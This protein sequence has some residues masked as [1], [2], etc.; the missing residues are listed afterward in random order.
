[1][2]KGRIDAGKEQLA[3]ARALLIAHP[4]SPMS[5]GAFGPFHQLARNCARVFQTGVDIWKRRSVTVNDPPL[6]RQQVKKICLHSTF[7]IASRAIDPRR[8]EPRF[9]L[10]MPDNLQ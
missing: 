10:E 1:M 7:P 9:R 5:P 2:I 8:G 4:Q 3:K 6:L